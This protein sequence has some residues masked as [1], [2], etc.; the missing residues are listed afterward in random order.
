MNDIDKGI[1]IEGFQARAAAREAS[2]PENLTDEQF[3][4]LQ[5]DAHLYNQTA[6]EMMSA[7]PMSREDQETGYRLILRGPSDID[8]NTTSRVI[9]AKA[10]WVK[11]AI[12]SAEN[13]PQMKKTFENWKTAF[14]MTH[15]EPPTLEDVWRHACVYAAFQN[16]WID[17]NEQTPDNDEPVTFCYG[18]L[19]KPETYGFGS[20]HYVDGKFTTDHSSDGMSAENV[21]CW[22][23]LLLPSLIALV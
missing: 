16:R 8:T 15:T 1:S 11:H 4:Q 14:G 20:G 21:L 23:P 9:G 7:I 19:D 12:H 3:N 6:F 22:K 10:L 5:S 17:V 18:E 2:Y 13:D